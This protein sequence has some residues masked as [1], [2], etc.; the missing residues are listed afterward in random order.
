M[1]RDA[2]TPRIVVDPLSGRTAVFAPKRGKRPHGHSAKG[3]KD[4]LAS[5]EERETVFA[6]RGKD[7]NWRIRV[8]GNLYPSFTPA[9]REAYGHQDLIVEGRRSTATLGTLPP[10]LVREIVDVWAERTAHYMRDPKVGYIVVFHSWGERS[11]ASIGHPHSQIYASAFVPP[12]LVAEMR[13]ANRLR[14]RGVH[15]VLAEARRLR[16]SSLAVWSRGGLLAYCPPASRFPYETWIT[17]L[18]PVDNIAELT[19]GE[20]RVLADMLRA[21]ARTLERHDTAFNISCHQLVRQSG[22]QLVIRV[23]PRR[24][25]PAG[26]ELDA[27]MYLNPVFPEQ[28]AQRLRRGL[29][30]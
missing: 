27:E 22:E 8:V 6:Q 21:L 15:P 4:F 29:V 14:V 12:W 10:S 28:A 17:P 5:I 26:V 20:R 1:K 24:T 23:T 13:R 30:Q 3:R 7:P 2:D 16:R 9:Y 19:A 18:R 25:I 11:G